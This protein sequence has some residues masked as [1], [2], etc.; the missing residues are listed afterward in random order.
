MFVVFVYSKLDYDYLADHKYEFSVVATDGGSPPLT[1]S[2][3]VQV[4]TEHF[5]D[6]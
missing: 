4:V 1:G 6:L 2:A 5:V 3:T